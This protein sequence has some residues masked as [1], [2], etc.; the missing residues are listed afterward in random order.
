MLEGIINTQPTLDGLLGRCIDAT[1]PARRLR[2]GWPLAAI[3]GLI[4]HPRLVLYIYSYSTISATV[5]ISHLFTL[6][7][8]VESKGHDKSTNS[9]VESGPV[10]T[11]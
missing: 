4:R 9:T 2:L 8:C 7:H 10:G 3:H 1:G 6:S 5:T 11:I